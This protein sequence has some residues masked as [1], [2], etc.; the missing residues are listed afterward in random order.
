MA[1]IFITDHPWPKTDLE[2]GLLEAAGHNLISGPSVPAPATTIEALVCAANPSAIMTC[3]AMVSAAAIAAAPNLRH[4]ARLGVGLDN[5]DVAAA[6]AHG[7]PVSNVPDYCF[8]EVSDHAI[9]LLLAL[10][11]GLTVADRSVKSGAWL[12]GQA[13]LRRFRELTIGLVGYGR[14]GRCAAGKLSGFGV[15]LLAYTPSGATDGV[16]L[17]VTLD[18]LSAESDAII[19][20]APLTPASH[21]LFNRNRIAS[22][23]P[24]SV[25]INVSRGA[26]IDNAALIE[27]LSSGH[28]GGAGL[29]VIDGEP[30]V[31][32]DLVDRP[33]VI[34]TPHM[35]FSSTTAIDELRRRACED[36]IRVLAGEPPLNLCNQP[37]VRP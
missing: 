17:P 2:Q 18:R 35:A 28:L 19:I 5:I 32:R 15:R 36:V 22:M 10:S 14:I 31:P 37:L 24:G 20:V 11:R 30:D 6:T 21:N 4:V 16:A 34:V 29:D 26:I 23:K 8:E 12:P 7:M 33:D 1:D 13:S 9:A 27:A 25:L 3:W